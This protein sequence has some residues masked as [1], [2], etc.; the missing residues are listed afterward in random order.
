VSLPG[1]RAVRLRGLLR[2][3]T[4]VAIC[5]GLAAC[6]GS[7]GGPASVGQATSLECAPFARTLSGIALYGEAWTWW[8]QAG[9]H[10]VRGSTP[11]PGAVLVFRRSARL[12]YGHVSVVARVR[13]AREI[14]VTQA[15]WVH[16]RITRDEPVVDVSAAGDWSQVRVW[17]AP[18][19]VM[20]SGTY[21]TYGFVGPGNARSDLIGVGP[22]SELPVTVLAQATLASN[23]GCCH[24][25][26]PPGEAGESPRRRNDG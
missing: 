5:L 12:P 11:T 25:C 21:P 19:R 3:L 6:G 8:E 22:P 4:G 16:R 24:V 13:S 17:W 26:P 23:F 15:N 1:R 9:G 2:S 14:T 10:Y 20:G 7:R 18:S